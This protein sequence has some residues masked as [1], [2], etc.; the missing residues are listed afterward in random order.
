MS[1][2]F[3]SDLHLTRERPASTEFFFDFAR[4]HGE[5]AEA[6]YVLGDLFEYWIGDDAATALT[7]EP[8]V[9]TFKQLAQQGI[10]LYFLSGNRD[11]L[12]GQALCQQAGFAYL[13]DETVQTIHGT[14]CLLLHGDSLCTDDIEHQNFRRMVLDSQWQQEFLAK[15]VETRMQ[16][17]MQ[18]RSLSNSNKPEYS[19]D[20][21]DVTQSAVEDAFTNHQ[22]PVMIHGH[23]HRPDIHQYEING[24]T[25]H[26]IVLGDWY[27][28][29]SY[30]V[31][32]DGGFTLWMGGESKTLNV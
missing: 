31:V 3:I 6:I 25:C 14:P 32:D 30:L 10:K 11:F 28:Q 18:A 26:R 1:T 7:V 8:I 5:K 13:Q 12:V 21:M 4:Q 9:E 29:A 20:I 27:D 16:M 19:S 15:P 17:A 24:K 22:V 23:T 2:L